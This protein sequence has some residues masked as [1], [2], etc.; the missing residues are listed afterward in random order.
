M[1]NRGLLKKNARDSLPVFACCYIGLAAFCLLFVGAIKTMGKELIEF[2]SN[3]AFLVK[4]FEMGFGIQL[5]DTVSLE[6]LFGVCFTH[7]VT[8]ALM[9]VPLISGSM[10]PVVGEIEKGTA[11]WLLTLP[12]SRTAVIWNNF[13]VNSTLAMVN[14]TAPMLGIYLAILF[15]KPEEAVNIVSYV[16]VAANLF[17]LT[18][19]V[20]GITTLVSCLL[21]QRNRVLGIVIGICIASVALNFLEPF[22]PAFKWLRPLNLL[23]YFRPVDIVREKAW[24]VGSMAILVTG[25]MLCTAVGNFIF[26][27]KDIPAA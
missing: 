6:I 19:M 2:I 15:F 20:G 25:A 26:C 7:L 5:S 14:A 10:R 11:D 13:I 16:P 22:F 8:L 1:L 4:I 21:N 9:W 17:C 24:P 23:G 18:L 27:R 12:V 3:F